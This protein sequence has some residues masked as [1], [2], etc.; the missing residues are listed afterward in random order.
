MYMY[1]HAPKKKNMYTSTYIHII[2]LIHIFIL[3]TSNSVAKQEISLHSQNACIWHIFSIYAGECSWHTK[4]VSANMFEKKNRSQELGR[5]PSAPSTAPTFINRPGLHWAT[6]TD[7]PGHHRPT[8]LVHPGHHGDAP[9]RPRTGGDRGLCD[10]HMS[11]FVFFFLPPQK[12]V[13][14]RKSWGLLRCEEDTCS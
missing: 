6:S 14:E 3:F 9:G 5:V 13:S 2:I 10:A 11:H 7:R 1:I 8:H 4:N 12:P